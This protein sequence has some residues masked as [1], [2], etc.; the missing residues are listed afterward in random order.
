MNLII[1]KVFLANFRVGSRALKRLMKEHKDILENPIECIIKA[2]PID[3]DNY[4]LWEAVI[5]GP[6][7]TFYQGGVYTARLQFTED[8]PFI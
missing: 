3:E 1:Q 5:K 6:E 4:F 7:D 2:G 8:Y